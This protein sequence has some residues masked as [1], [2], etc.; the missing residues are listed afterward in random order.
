MQV[1]KQLVIFILGW[2]TRRDEARDHGLSDFDRVRAELRPCDVVLVEGTSK[3]DRVIQTVS[4]C[5]WSHAALYIGRPLDIADA[6][7]KTIISHF[8][9]GSPDTHLLVESRLGEGIVVTPLDEYEQEHLRVC[10]PKSLNE[11]DV[12]QVIRFAIN[13]LGAHKG[14]GYLFDLLR[15]FFPWSLLPVSWRGR[16]FRRWAGRHTK[17]VTAAFI[18]ECFGFIQFPIYP[19]VKISGEQGVQLL[20]RHPLL[21]MPYEIDQSPN[22]EIVKY[23]FIDFKMYEQERLIP[24]K[25]SGIYSGMDQDPALVFKASE[26]LP[27]ADLTSLVNKNTAGHSEDSGNVTPINSGK[28]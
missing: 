3:S 2:L 23:P 19:L 18:A 8:F 21:C 25:G 7:L 5:P 24:W 11:K 14:S 17:N 13:R 20:R 9:T 15:F 6:D 1:F 28:E 4:R 22:F 10:R 12:S 16:G 27:G 26:P